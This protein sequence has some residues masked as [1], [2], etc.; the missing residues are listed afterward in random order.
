MTYRGRI[1]VWAASASLLAGCGKQESPE[2]SQAAPGDDVAAAVVALPVAAHLGIAT[3]VP[4]DADLFFAGYGADEMILGLA[5]ALVATGMLIPMELEFSDSDEPP[6]E[7]EVAGSDETFLQYAPYVGDEGF[8]YIGP[9]LGSQARMVGASY[10]EFSAAWTG[11]AVGSLLDRLGEKEGEPDFSGLEDSLSEDLLEKWLDVIEKDERL[12]VPSLV[13]G[14]RP[15]AEKE[16]E[17]RDAVAKGLESLL[18][19]SDEVAPV[20]FEAA[21]VSMIGH[22]FSGRE[23]FGELV[24]TAREE[25]QKQDGGAEALEKISPERIERLL[26]AMEQVRLTIASGSVDGRIVIY[27]GNGK[28]GFRLAETPETS[29]AGT[30][31]LKWT[32]GYAE[33]RIAGVAYL[34]EA[35]VGAA[36]PW[37]DASDYWL[38]LS[39][40]IRPP[41]RE[42]RLFRELLVS[43]ADTSRE[44]G[45]RNASAWS[46][47]VVQDQGWRYESRG[48]WA[49]PGLDYTTPLRMTDAA[50][51]RSPAVRMH[52]VRNRGRNDVSWKQ[53]EQFGLLAESVFNE[54]SA[55]D[56]SL[57]AMVPDGAFPRLMKEM[58]DLNRAYREEFHEGIGDEVA[59][60][61]DLKGEVP[62]LPGISEE[63]VATARMP[64]FIVARPVV[65]RA[66][67]DASG[68]SFSASWKSLTGWASELSGSE[69]P[70]ILPQKIES[71]DRVTWYP[72]LPFIG[73]DFVPG[74]TLSDS[75]W[76][77]GTS[78]S[79]AVEF[80]RSMATPA[81][82][83]ETGM[84][85]EIDFLP[86]RDWLGDLYR[87]NEA[88]VAGLVDQYPVPMD[89]LEREK[90]E[91]ATSGL[92][93]LDG[94]SLR[95]WLEG[96]KPRTSIHLRVAPEE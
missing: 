62:P 72:P 1:M 4:A 24:A 20:A 74:V 79:M 45:R 66:K 25:L 92:K 16:A 96:G 26:V 27:L 80:A 91:N 40:A 23:L 14:W 18:A 13:M 51:G 3:R 54:F 67:V 39:R 50:I 32:H 77:L 81:S 10:R 57:S 64:R 53:V 44:L 34:S 82:G 83:G 33:Q 17:C 36:L 95:K 5:R 88:E 48:G 76:M 31:D 12:Q 7:S 21:G 55:A 75:L 65:D 2:A 68:A 46:A 63:T 70:L 30:E 41:V 38:S 11:F 89:D 73:G 58:R 35:M 87:R 56:S 37:L 94:L 71:D 86:I 59:F 61:M 6:V 60:V 19:G 69:L 28:E 15:H 29:L 8:L 90:L 42:E 9:G 49:D 93:S 22:E 47:V 52:W 85:V 43:M 84:I 78:Q